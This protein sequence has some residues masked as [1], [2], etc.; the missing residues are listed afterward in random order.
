VIDLHC[1]YLPG[2]DDGAQTL[3]ESLDLARAAVNAGI[4]VAVLTP[5]VHPGRYDN[6]AASITKLCTAFKQVLAHRAIPLDVRA[7]GEVRISEDILPMVETGAIPFLG[8]LGGYR[9]MLL[10]FPHSH[11]TLGAEKLIAWLLSHGI[12]PLI[13]HPER[14]KE[15]MRQPDKL[16]PFIE[17]GC[18]LQL[19]GASIIGRFGK[20]AQACAAQL[21]ERNWVA[22]VATDAH[23]L[24][25]RPPNLDEAYRAL[26][27][28]GGES[29]ALELTRG[30]PG[31]IIGLPSSPAEPHGSRRSTPLR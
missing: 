14:N 11:L 4:E 23:N 27:E 30:M 28:I 29:F 22:A 10:E 5:H 21:I 15:V 3:E 17:M 16:R 1:H 31:R 7:G 9:I 25:H 24:T 19:T 13:A 8:E 26:T 18:L 12:R 20:P 6:N 2:I